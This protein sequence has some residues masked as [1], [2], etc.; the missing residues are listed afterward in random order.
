MTDRFAAGLSQI[1]LRY[2]GRRQAQ[3][4]SQTADL[5]ARGSSLLASQMIGQ[6]L[7]RCRSATRFGPVVS[8]SLTSFFST[9]MA[10]SET[11]LRTCDSVMECGVNAARGD[12]LMNVVESE[13]TILDTRCARRPVERSVNDGDIDRAPLW[14]LSG[15]S[16]P[17]A[18]ASRRVNTEASAV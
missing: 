3:S 12:A 1:L 6:I 18:P 5:L 4:W 15:S 8:W 2:P 17:A 11:K 7:A 9:N 14:H 10:I 13:R 16:R